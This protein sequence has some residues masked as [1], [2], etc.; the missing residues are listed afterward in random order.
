MLCCCVPEWEVETVLMRWGGAGA[1]HRLSPRGAG[2][3]LADDDADDGK[4]VLDRPRLRLAWP[5]IEGEGAARDRASFGRA[6]YREGLLP[7]ETVLERPR[8]LLPFSGGLYCLS[9][10]AGAAA[11]GV[12]VAVTLG[13]SAGGRADST[14]TD[15]LL[16]GKLGGPEGGRGDGLWLTPVS[17]GYVMFLSP[18]MR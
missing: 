17:G 16:S 4:S 14:A 11:D 10:R 9:G 12:V 3:D 18:E 13:G 7:E 5:L 8:L 1:T 6:P 2:E 15:R